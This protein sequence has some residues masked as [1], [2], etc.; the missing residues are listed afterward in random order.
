M[1]KVNQIIRVTIDINKE[2]PHEI[3]IEVMAADKSFGYS[4]AKLVPRFY[5]IPPAD[6]IFEFDFIGDE[7]LKQGNKE[8]PVFF[9]EYMLKNYPK[10]LKGIRVHAKVNFMERAIFRNLDLRMN[11]AQLM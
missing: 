8:R 4:T 2:F 1:K 6:A 9:A 7:P 5:E 3:R 10:N 11:D